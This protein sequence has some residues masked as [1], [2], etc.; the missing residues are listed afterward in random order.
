MAFGTLSS[1]L[2]DDQ[3]FRRAVRLVDTTILNPGSAV[4]LAQGEW[5]APNALD[6]TRYQRH[7]PVGEHDGPD[8]SYPACGSSGATDQQAVGK[9]EIYYNTQG[10]FMTTS[11]N[12]GGAGGYAA[13]THLKV[14]LINADYG[15]GAE[16]R[17]VL[18]PTTGAADNIVATVE[19]APSDP[20]TMEPMRIRLVQF[21]T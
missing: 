5:L 17:S 14:N 9:A 21:V 20:A 15:N 8:I 4:P 7:A 6:G 2:P 12:P 11:Y 16:D 3:M 10:S 18:T 19:V 13:G 1:N